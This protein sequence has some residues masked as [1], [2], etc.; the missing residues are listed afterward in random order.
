MLV[1][2][3][4]PVQVLDRVPLEEETANAEV[5]TVWSWLPSM[6][7]MLTTCQPGAVAA[8]QQH[9]VKQ[10]RL[11]AIVEE[12]KEPVPTIQPSSSPTEPMKRHYPRCLLFKYKGRMASFFLHPPRYFLP[13]P[14]LQQK[15][16]QDFSL[17]MVLL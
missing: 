1:L 15:L 2:P 11:G 13:L 14:V 9:V 16:S 17:Q 4:N 12:K 10:Q 7:S 8:K 6:L 3:R 5:G